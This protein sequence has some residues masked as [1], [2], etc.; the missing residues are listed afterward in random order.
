MGSPWRIQRGIRSA[1]PPT[2]MNDL[3][4]HRKEAQQDL[5]GKRAAHTVGLSGLPRPP[6]A[7]AT[8]S[9]QIVHAQDWRPWRGPSTGDRA[10][11][12]AAVPPLPTCR[13]RPPPSAV[14]GGGASR[15]PPRTTHLRGPPA[16]LPPPA[17]TEW[18]L[19]DAPM[20]RRGGVVAIRPRHAGPP[21]LPLHLRCW[22]SFGRRSSLLPARKSR[23]RICGFG[24]S[25]G[26]CVLV[27]PRCAQM[28]FSMSD[29]R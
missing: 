23:H 28:G 17:Q 9:R 25:Q 16:T 20:Q 15:P 3:D 29:T 22:G 8:P 21:P 13:A 6:M 12:A 4:R 7:A 1:R 19:L 27:C 26:R 10:R 2:G 24:R 18:Q 5:R 14:T 11:T